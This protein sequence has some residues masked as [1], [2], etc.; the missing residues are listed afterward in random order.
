MLFELLVVSSGVTIALAA[1]RAGVPGPAEL[2]AL[3]CT[4]LVVCVQ[5]L[6]M[7]MKW[8]VRSPYAVDLRSARATPAPP[9]VMVG[10]SA[11]LALATTLTGLVFQGLAR[12][13]EWRVSVAVAVPFLIFASLRLVRAHAAWVQP[14]TRSR[15][16]ATAAA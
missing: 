10:Y 1:V 7:S 15:V 5:V 11:K 8:S 13:P 16:V 3:L 9:L 14:V 2:A 4:W 12:V 6:A